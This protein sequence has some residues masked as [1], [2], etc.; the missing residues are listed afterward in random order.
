MMKTRIFSPGDRVRVGTSYHWAEGAMGTV[1]A[2]PEVV[3]R[4]VEDRDPWDGWTRRVKGRHRIITFYWIWFDEP[5]D[6][7]DGD[8]PYKGGEVDE[9]ALELA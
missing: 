5:Q 3:Q 8:G 6:D 2:P 9:D 1:A 4:L 7:A